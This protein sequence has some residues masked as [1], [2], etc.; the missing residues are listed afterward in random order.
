MAKI[1][2]GDHVHYA[3]ENLEA[4][5]ASLTPVWVVTETNTKYTHLVQT[6]APGL[7]AV[8]SAPTED[9]VAAKAEDPTENPPSE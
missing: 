2:I 3:P 1:S 6:G 9:L 4:E 5:D 7:S 8:S